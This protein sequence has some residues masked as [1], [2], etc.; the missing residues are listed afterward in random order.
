MKKICQL[1]CFLCVINLYVTAQV[2]LPEPANTTTEQQ[3]ENITENSEDL[4][5]EDDSYLQQ[6]NQLQRNPVNINNA[7]ETFLKDLR[8]LTPMQIQNFLAYRSVLG[9]LINMYEL[10]AV[11]GWD[12]VT[13][14]KVRPFISVSNGQ[15]LL[16]DIGT[17]LRNGDNSILVRLTQTLEK[18]KGYLIDSSIAKNFYPGSPQRLFVRY[19]YMYKNLL[20]YGVVG[21]K[22]AG[23]EF[24]KGSQKKGFDFYS[25]HFF[26]RNAGIIKSLALG[27]FTVNMGQGLTQWMSLAFKKGPDIMSVKRQ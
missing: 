16:A 20:Q 2:P 8:M 9:K 27:D 15:S 4:E 14:Q 24:F 13:I 23:E 12:L 3:L 18:S 22:D 7:D 17:R 6:L 1:I 19:K 25:A 11:P 10:Q 21:E 26:V 5:T